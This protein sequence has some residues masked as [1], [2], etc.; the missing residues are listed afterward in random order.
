MLQYSVP[1]RNARLDTVESTIGA[2]PLIE[3]RS[4]D[5]PA[6]CAAADSGTLLAQGTLPADWMAAASGGSKAKNGTWTI[7]GLATGVIG[8]F[9]I[10]D[11]GSPD[12]CHIQGSVGPVGSPDYDMEV[13]NVNIAAA[14]QVTV[15][16][17][18]LT[19]G[20]D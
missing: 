11:A 14:Q 17:F 15:N 7:V 9:R 2:S 5:A 8:H 20:N 1:V 12:T 4:G 10:K 13:D 16:S 18:T 6:N 3:L 19:A